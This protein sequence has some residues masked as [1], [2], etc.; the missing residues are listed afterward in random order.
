L[1][2]DQAV[3]LVHALFRTTLYVVGPVLAVALAAGLVVGVIQTA[4][5]INESSISFLVKVSAVLAVLVVLGPQL[6]SYVIDYTRASLS[7]IADVVH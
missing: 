3:A 1:N 7:S 5:Q 6:A 2:P 4:T